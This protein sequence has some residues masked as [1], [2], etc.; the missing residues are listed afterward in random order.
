VISQDVRYALRS[1]ARAPGFTLVALLTLALGIGATT[2][3]FSVVDGILLRPL[4]YPDPERIVRVLNTTAAN[5][6]GGGFSAADYLDYK[7]ASRSFDA[8]AGYRQD[9]V[10]LTGDADPVRLTAHET[11][12]GYFDV[13][14]VPAMLGRVYSERTDSPY[15]PRIAVLSAAVWKQ[16]LGSDASA[17]G[18]TI[19]LNGI[20]TTVVGVMPEFFAHPPNPDLWVLA[21]NDVPTSP[22]AIDGAAIANR[23]V[24]Y[25]EVVGRLRSGVTETQANADLRSTADRLARE[26]VE[27]NDG[28]SAM[29]VAFQESLVDSVR[30]ALYVLFGAVAFVLLIACANVAGLLL[31]RGAARRRE[32]AVRTALGAASGRLIRQLLTES[33]VL[34]GAGGLLGLLLAYW[35][36]EA[37][38][39]MAPESIP[40]LTA[41]HLDPRVALFAVAA[42]VLVGVLFGIVPAI[43]GSR[44]DMVGALKDGGRTGTAR[45]R[46]RNLLVVVE[47]ALALVL[48]IGAGLMLTSFARLRSVD[49]GFTVT[50]LV[51]IGVPLP[52][53]RYDNAAQTRFYTQLYER[54]RENPVTSRSALAL[55]TPF[56]G[57]NAAAAYAVEGA[58][59]RPRS[60]RPVTQLSAVTPGYFQA[61]GIPLLRGR[62]VEL[63]D[64]KDRQG[65]VLVNQVIAEREWPGQDPVGKRVA[66]GGDPTDPESWTTVV[67]VVADIRR[68]D[69][70]TP[71]PPTMYLPHGQFTLPY[72]GVIVRSDAGETAIAN[73][74]RAA[75]RRLDPELPIED[76]ETVDR[77]LERVTGQPRFRALLIASFAGAALLLAAIGLYGLIS[78]TVAQRSPEIGVRLALGATPRQ[79]GRQVL[80]QGMTL[81]ALG[82]ALGLAAAVGATR[83]LEGLL[84][85]ISTT[86]PAVYGVVAAVLLIIAA[87]ACYIPARRAMRVDPM[88]ALRAE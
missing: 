49:P 63:T 67:G 5:R 62:D 30:T 71:P 21:P 29:T 46:T 39:A 1:L 48:L 70:Q 65:V 58:P 68:A 74:V 78:Y 45:T 31:A 23:E 16:H 8:F 41:V 3:I 24:N 42:T 76:V 18:R 17:I 12:A 32:F 83:L 34:A 26:H 52:Q 2:A 51:V 27:T 69:L 73:A 86:D 40:R 53:A 11:T 28:E 22:V 15:G 81:A 19:R 64:T 75:V 10:D 79:V 82:V 20:P 84:Y 55:P 59:P 87:L 72:M 4:P 66:I 6:E 85:S 60:E 25:F 35:G 14:A 54:L 43:Q 33:L 9:V 44:T 47:V 88:T 37:L 13:F 36:V 77:I 61:L 80:G 56:S 38:L 7:S 50:S 57:L